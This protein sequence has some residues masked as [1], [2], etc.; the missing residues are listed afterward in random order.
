MKYC[1]SLTASVNQAW[2][3]IVGS[4]GDKELR[5]FFILGDVLTGFE[6]GLPISAAEEETTWLTK[7]Y[8]EFE[9]KAR[10]GDEEFVGLP[11]DIDERKELKG[12][13]ERA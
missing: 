9:K 4:S 2:C 6:V 5:A 3:S 13:V 8:G 10:E 1:H 12:A 11:K 7:Y